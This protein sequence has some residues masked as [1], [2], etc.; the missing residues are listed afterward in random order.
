MLNR[1]NIA[2]IPHSAQRYNTVG[3]YYTA[4]SDLVKVRISELQNADYEFLIM[5]HEL[6]ESYL[7]A[8]RGISEAQID[9]FDVEHSELDEP[10][11]SEDAPYHKEHMF[12]TSIEQFIAHELGVDWTHYEEALQRIS[13]SVPVAE[14]FTEKE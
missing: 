14:A 3:D 10:G 2:V 8:K 13:E 11:L 9:T 4:H 6:V 5:I 12:A 1:Y 7:C